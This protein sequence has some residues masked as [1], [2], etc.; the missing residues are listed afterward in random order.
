MQH[1]DFDCI[2]VNHLL[3]YNG[4]FQIFFQGVCAVF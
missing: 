3:S 1:V 4:K 2:E